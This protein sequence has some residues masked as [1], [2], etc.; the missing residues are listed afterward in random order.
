[1][2]PSLEREASA[3]ARHQPAP[4]EQQSSPPRTRTQAGQQSTKVRFSS[5]MV[6]QPALFLPVARLP[7]QAVADLRLIVTITLCRGLTLAERLLRAVALLSKLEPAQ[8][9]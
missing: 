3:G 6:E 8:R 9:F 4:V 5:A 1:M 2:G 7:P